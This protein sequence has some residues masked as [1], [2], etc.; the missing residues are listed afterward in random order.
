MNR[1]GHAGGLDG[2]IENAL[3]IVAS[4]C[5][6]L[7]SKHREDLLQELNEVFDGVIEIPVIKHVSLVNH[8]HALNPVLDHMEQILKEMCESNKALG[9]RGRDSKEDSMDTSSEWEGEMRR[10]VAKHGITIAG[11]PCVSQMFSP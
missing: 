9:K 11:F 10:S 7:Y 1:S 6:S 8:S 4:F 3:A 2:Q 5:S